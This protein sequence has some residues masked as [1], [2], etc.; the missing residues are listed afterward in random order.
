M[1]DYTRLYN[2]TIKDSLPSGNSG[3]VIKGAE[4]DAEYN[5][6]VSAIA[7]KSDINSPTF[8]GTPAAP[9]AVTGTSTTQLATTAFVSTSPTI[10]SPTFLGVPVAPTAS[11]GTNTTQI[12][13]T[14]HVFAERSN[15]ATLTN[16]SINLADNTLTA[17]SAQVAAAVTDETGS[18]SLVFGTAPTISSANLTGTPVAPTAA[19]GT[20]TTQLATTAFVQAALQALYPVGSVYINASSTTNPS[21]LLGFGTWV[22]VGDGKV[23]VNQDTADTSFDTLGETGGSKD[24]IVV[25]HTHTYSTTTGSAGGHSHTITDPGHTHTV[26]SNSQDG[27]ST[28]GFQDGVNPNGRFVTSTSS[29]TGIT[30]NSVADHTHS[31]SGTTASTGSSGTNANLQPYVVVKM[32]KRT[33]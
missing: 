20:N 32:W 19:F 8:T 24:T 22:S 4:L 31:V 12:A 17:T 3:K 26:Q 21:S 6:I 23:L 29:T 33:A 11:A 28:T 27:V 9:T 13:T 10:T 18:G 15:S 2:L 16:K 7:S 30:V 5:A 1:S 25:S 14:A